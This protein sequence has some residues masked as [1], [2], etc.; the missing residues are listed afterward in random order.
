MKVTPLD[1]R[2]SQFKTAM[3]G[4]DK[5]EVKM[6]LADAAD[7]YEAALR[8]IDRLRQ[9][10][11]RME[12]ALGE[13]RDRESNLR[14]TLLT[15][16]RL[17]DQVRE[18]AEQEARITIREA[19]GKAELLI[20]KA[21]TRLEEIGDEITEL[22]RR[23]RDAET[24]LESTIGALTSTL[25]AIRGQERLER[26]DFGMKAR[27][28]ATPLGPRPV[29]IAQNVVA[30]EP[31]TLPVAAAVAEY[32]SSSV[33][34]PAGDSSASDSEEE[35]MLAQLRQLAHRHEQRAALRDVTS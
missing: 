6:L 16:Q 32:G 3:R 23:R 19:E 33:S 1:L 28:A 8:E 4:F 27:A 12:A 22:K 26:D 2:Q 18:Q 30:V 11:N 13:H 35:E 17:A 29:S 14:N 9:D 20:Q 31:L 24:S 21:Q 7:D 10:V 15:A 25:E 5:V 34:L